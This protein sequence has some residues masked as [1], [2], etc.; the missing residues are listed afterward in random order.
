MASTSATATAPRATKKRRNR[1]YCCVVNCHEREGLDNN[2]QFYRFP[3][4]SYEG[5]RRERWIRAVQRVGPDGGLWQPSENSRICSRHFVGNRKSNV[6]NH[7]AYVPSIFPSVYRRPPP[8]DSASGTE[9]FGRWQ[10]RHQADAAATTGQSTDIST[11]AECTSGTVPS[12]CAAQEHAEAEMLNIHSIETEVPLVIEGGIA[13]SV[14]SPQRLEVV[15][16]ECASETAVNQQHIVRTVAVGPSTRTC[17]FAGFHSIMGSPDAL[18][19]LCGVDSNVFALLLSLL[20]SVRERSSDVTVENKLLMFLMKMKLGISFS[21]VAILFGVHEKTASRTFYAVLH[22]LAEITKDW[23]YKPPITDI[24]LS[25]PSCFKINY[26]QCTLIIDCT[27]MKTETPSEVPTWKLATVAVRVTPAFFL[28]TTLQNEITSGTLGL[29]PPRTVG[30]EGLLPYFLVGDEAFP[31][32]DCMMRP[33]HDGVLLTAK[34]GKGDFPL[35]AGGMRNQPEVP[36]CQLSPVGATL[37]GM[38]KKCGTSWHTTSSQPAKF[39][40]KIKWSPVFEL[41][42]HL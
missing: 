25:Q 17:F 20:P 13:D 2:V 42:K 8:L 26:P 32:K 7:P 3:S 36:S 27:E 1:R 12:S 40:G 34:T 31:L 39:P 5:E 10:K 9:R 23:I 18:R 11:S 41:H 24:M 14:L 4:R 16:A 19:S 30:S 37:L 21:A 33:T 6:A 28:D 35:A 29:P 22:T 38:R 15:P